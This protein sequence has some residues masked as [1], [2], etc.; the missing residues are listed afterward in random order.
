ML[1]GSHLRH[2]YWYELQ[3]DAHMITK[4]EADCYQTDLHFDPNYQY[5]LSNG[6]KTKRVH[7]NVH[8]IWSNGLYLCTDRYIL[9]SSWK[10]HRLCFQSFHY[11]HYVY[12]SF[13][14][15]A[16]APLLKFMTNKWISSLTWFRTLGSFW[17][18]SI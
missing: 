15:M 13:T 8:N 3:R 1:N 14:W 2:S 6:K 9:N 7:P 12:T 5:E 11:C 18:V 17:K 4:S 10:H 16:L